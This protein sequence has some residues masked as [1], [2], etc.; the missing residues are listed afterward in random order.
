MFLV[1]DMAFVDPIKIFKE[2]RATS[3]D[4]NI[5]PHQLD[6]RVDCFSG[7][8]I[9]NIISFLADSGGQQ[10]ILIIFCGGRTRRYSQCVKDARPARVVIGTLGTSPFMAAPPS[11]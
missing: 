1:G 5:S 2:Y 8:N 7:Q 11:E 9:T 10:E 6:C 3:K 4:V